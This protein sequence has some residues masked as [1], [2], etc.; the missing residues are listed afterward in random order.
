MPKGEICKSKQ[1]LDYFPPPDRFDLLRF[2]VASRPS[3]GR[4]WYYT[5]LTLSL[6]FVVVVAAHQ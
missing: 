2:N 3:A 5:I 1:R 6:V 4:C